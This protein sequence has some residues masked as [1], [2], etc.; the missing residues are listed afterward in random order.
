VAPRFPPSALAGENP[1][2][3]RAPA[4][5]DFSVFSGYFDCRGLKRHHGYAYME[6]IGLLA[7][8]APGTGKAPSFHTENAS[9]SPERARGFGF[10]KMVKIGDLDCLSE[11]AQS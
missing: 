9:P 6:E 10:V 3:R 11:C 1:S 7:I 5:W 4:R 8:T 2:R